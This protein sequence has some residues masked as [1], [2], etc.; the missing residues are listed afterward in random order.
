M[1]R[2]PSVM[3]PHGMLARMHAFAHCQKCTPPHPFLNTRCT[4]IIQVKR[5]WVVHAK[6]SAEVVAAKRQPNLFVQPA[7]Y[8]LACWL[9]SQKDF[10][11]AEKHLLDVVDIQV[12]LL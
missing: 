10:T 9:I 4:N 2:H 11:K 7:E 1:L 3:Q 8:D 12:S 6:Q 5:Q